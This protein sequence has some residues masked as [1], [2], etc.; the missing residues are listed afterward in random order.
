[1]GHQWGLLW[2][3]VIIGEKFHLPH[4]HLEHVNTMA[5]IP[6]GGL[7]WMLLENIS[8]GYRNDSALAFSVHSH[9]TP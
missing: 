5:T 8:R 2:Y 6:I 7:S 4:V 9:T 1:M 3:V